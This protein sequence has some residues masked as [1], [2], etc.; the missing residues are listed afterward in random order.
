[1]GQNNQKSDQPSAVLMATLYWPVRKTANDGL[2]IGLGRVGLVV[3]DAELAAVVQDQ[4][5]GD[6]VGISRCK[7]RHGRNSQ[8]RTQLPPLPVR[9][10]AIRR[11]RLL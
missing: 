11:L 3:G 6:V 7:A 4:V 9:F 10:A 5:D 2:A 1:M 8:T